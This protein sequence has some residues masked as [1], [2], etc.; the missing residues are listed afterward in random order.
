MLVNAENIAAVREREADTL[1]THC[2]G[3]REN[4]GVNILSSRNLR[5][6]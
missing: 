6:A 2:Q 1:H 5:M 4:V 3:F